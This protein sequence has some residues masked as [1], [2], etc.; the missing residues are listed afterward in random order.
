MKD[1]EVKKLCEICQI[2]PSKAEARKK[3]SATDLVSFIPMSNLG[4]QSK[5]IP[6]SKNKLLSEVV[7]SYTYFANN[8][9]LLAK[10]TPC[11]E[12]GKIGIARDLTNG[13]G[14]GSS[15]YIVFRSIG[16][17][18]PE[19][20]FYFLSQN[21]FRNSGARLMTGAVGHKRV[22][23]DFIEN[24]PILVPPLSEQKRIVSI[25][26]EAFEAIDIAID[27]TKQ[28]LTNA[29]KLFDSYLN[30]IFTQKGDG[31]EE[32]N[33]SRICDVRDGTHDSPTYVDNGI[34]FIT[35]KNIRE[36]GLT[37][38]NVKFISDD[39]HKKFYTRSNVAFGDI[40]IS[41]IGA[42]R[43]MTCVVDDKRTFSIKNVG[44]IKSSKNI[45]KYFLLYFLKSNKAQ[46]YIESVSRGGAQ[47]F[48]GLGKLR[49][50]PV[51]I[52]PQN[53]Q[54]NIVRE[55]DELYS[56]TQR[57]K[58]IYQQKLT[59]LNELKQSILHKAFTGE[60]TAD[61]PDVMTNIDREAIAV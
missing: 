24:H 11:F 31:W 15:E 22:A 38:D 43:G 3:L 40:L 17:I 52:A 48:V 8:D 13:I 60:L 9:V 39:D 57:L 27:N 41:M 47:A 34:A 61:K 33:L 6:L 46:A 21:S 28:N 36:D 49:E 55:L 53:Q 25:V 51:S 58:T 23:K 4:I 12:N 5:A 45:D 2:N 20:L 59:A 14:F 10:I 42:N 1:W 16:I 26:D 56:E 44:L 30:V 7:G 35:Q 19:Y 32:T 18:E 54:A 29:R 50:F 37:F